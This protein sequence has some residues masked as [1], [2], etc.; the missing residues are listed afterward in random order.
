MRN[1]LKIS[2]KPFLFGMV[3]A[4][5]LL[6]S[7]VS[8]SAAGDK[9]HSNARIEALDELD[10]IEM[11][12]SVDVS[13]TSE[14]IQKFQTKEG[15]NRL[16]NGKYNPKGEC[17][18]EAYRNKEVLLIT[19]PAH[20]LFSPNETDLKQGAAEYLAPIRRY[21]KDPDMYRV[22][23]VMHTDNTGS[24]HYREQ[25]T[26]DRVNT[27]FDWFANSGSDTR[28]LFSYALGDDMPLR[29]ND[30]MENRDKNRR[31]E[32]YLVPG[33]S[34]LDQAKKGRISF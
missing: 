23:L 27:V 25:L 6:I 1:R 3:S 31:L 13:K 28:Y 29:P 18:V 26:A 12:N 10:F 8:A 17:T 34:M 19:I 2:Y 22:M 32:I 5:G 16:L 7:P 11:L 24:D 30:S 33:Q 4:V 15:K 21:L 20:L 14:L 9:D